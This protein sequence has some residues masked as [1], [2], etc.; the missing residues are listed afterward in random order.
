[1][2]KRYFTAEVKIAL[3]AIIALVLL[4]IG[5]NF[6]KGINVFKTSNNYYIEFSDILGLATS[7]PVYANGYA[8]GTVREIKYNYQNPGHV[9]VNIELDKEMRVPQG[10]KAEIEAEMLG[11][12]KICL[13]LPQDKTG[14]LMR[15]PAENCSQ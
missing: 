9:A 8:V 6:L 5:F 11:G 1:M 14:Y 4:F 13:V 2:S 15:S 3:T 12:V 10:T 7:S